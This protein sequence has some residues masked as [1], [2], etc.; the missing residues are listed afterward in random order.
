MSN[1]KSEPVDKLETIFEMEHKTKVKAKQTL[2]ELHKIESER[3]K[4]GD[5]HWVIIDEKTT[6]LRKVK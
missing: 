4:T 2:P 5:W 6:V 3:L 1:K